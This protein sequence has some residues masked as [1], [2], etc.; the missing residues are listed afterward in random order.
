LNVPAIVIDSDAPDI[1][2]QDW[3]VPELNLRQRDKDVLRSASGWLTDIIIDAAQLLLSFNYLHIPIAQTPLLQ[4]LDGYQRC[5]AEVVQILL[6]GQNHWITA[7]SLDCRRKGIRVFDSLS[8]RG[9]LAQVNKWLQ[10]LFWVKDIPQDQQSSFTV[11]PFQQ[12][13][14]NNDCGLYAIACAT[15]LAQGLDPSQCSYDQNKMRKHLIDCFEK[16][17]LSAFPSKTYVKPS[18]RDVS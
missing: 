11:V 1:S 15:S 17:H 3:W 12:Q 10:D 13:S 4:S 9:R 8:T 7:T 6:A 5:E 16:R 18:G 14:G 2:P